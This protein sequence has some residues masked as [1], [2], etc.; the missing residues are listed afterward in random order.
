MFINIGKYY[1]ISAYYTLKIISRTIAA[2]IILYLLPLHAG[3]TSTHPECVKL[4]V[5]R[6][7]WSGNSWNYSATDTL[8]IEISAG[9]E[10]GGRGDP[11]YFRLIR[12]INTETIEIQFSDNLVVAGEPL[13]YPSKQNPILISGRKNC[14]RTRLRDAGTDYCIDVLE[15]RKS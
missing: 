8:I 10:F 3:N 13:A 4:R 5:V 14:F 15:I 1:C 6:I 11:K 2:G 12:I 7:S 9:E